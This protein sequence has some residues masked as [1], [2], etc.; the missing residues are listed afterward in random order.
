MSDKV[1]TKL[2]MSAIGV[3]TESMTL[4]ETI[5]VI[6]NVAHALVKN[7]LIGRAEI[8]AAIEKT[9]DFEEPGIIV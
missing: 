3:I 7:K 8:L 6:A 1:R 2:V 9:I 5:T 4:E